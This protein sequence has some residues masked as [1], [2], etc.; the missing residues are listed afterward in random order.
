MG[1]EGILAVDPAANA[2]YIYQRGNLDHIGGFCT[3]S[4]SKIE[5]D[6]IK[7]LLA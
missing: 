7:G 3:V 4:R 6:E 2:Y 1:I 5:F